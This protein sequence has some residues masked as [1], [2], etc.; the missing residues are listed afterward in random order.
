VPG[1]PWFKNLGQ[2]E[3][4]IGRKYGRTMEVMTNRRE[5]STE[6]RKRRE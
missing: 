6:V 5:E 1:K 4:F 3:N 2:D